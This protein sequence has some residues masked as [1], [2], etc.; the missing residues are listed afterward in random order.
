MKKILVIDDQKSFLFKMKNLLEELIPNCKVFIAQSGVK[1]IEIAN[2][3]QPDTIL[4]DV[5]MPEMD[6][7]EVCEKLRANKPTRNIP[8]ILLSAYRNDID[9]KVKG[10]KS[11]ADVFLPKPFDSS[12]LSAQV[13]SMLRIREVE[14]K[15]NASEQRYY[16]IFENVND[17]IIIFNP[18]T[19]EILDINNKGVEMYGYSKEEIVNGI[20]LFDLSADAQQLDDKIVKTKLNEI[21]NNKINTFEGHA[22]NKAGKTFWV[23]VSPKLVIIDNAEK[24]L[25]SVRDINQR[26]QAEEALKESEEKFRSYIKNATDGVFVVNEKGEYIEVNQAACK[27][28]EYTEKELLELTIPDLLQ[29][30]YVEKAKNHFQAVIKDGS[31]KDELGYVTKTGE[32]KFWN[33]YAVKLSDTRF[34][35]FAKDI[36]ERKKT[37]QALKESEAQL[38]ENNKTKDK[39]FSIIAHDLRT[40]FFSMLG[41]SELLNEKFDQ[42]DT[43][44]KKKFTG[45]IYEGLQK[46]L[47]LL[48]NLLEWSRSQSGII[49]FNPEKTDLYSLVIEKLEIVNLSAEK[50]SIQIINQIAE[51]IYVEADKNML[52]TIIRNLLSNAIKF[53]NKQGKITIKTFLVP[54]EKHSQFIGISVNDTGVGIRKEIQ[55]TLFNIGENISTSGTENEEGT[56]LGLILCKEFVEK[57]GGKIWVESEVGKG[58]TFYF[59]IPKK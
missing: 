18:N 8:I 54:N 2:T 9:G 7:Y 31:A 45:I 23:E 34:L 52:A 59:T 24:L 14:K 29:Q 30:E 38:R 43:E 57:H 1:G 12:E 56:G 58:S 21:K 6:G 10:L 20:S 17:A 28:T 15:L 36:T 37:E 3:E 53:T 42:Y 49:D 44:K 5:V 51:N 47:K 32:N 13:T 48:D 25:V 16:S 4:L 46:T 22:K 41:F 27:I 55:S 39:F 35:G 40:P 50:K 11:G 33:I 26:K 19:L